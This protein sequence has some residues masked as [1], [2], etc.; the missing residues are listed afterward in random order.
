MSIRKLTKKQILKRSINTNEYIRAKELRVIGEDGAQLGVLTRE[1]ALQ[2]AR[3]LGVD[4]IEVA[5]KA[6]PPVARLIDF[7]KYLYLLSKKS[8]DENKGKTDIKE[9]KIGLFMAENDI[10]RIANRA[11]QFIKSGNQVKISLWLKGREL[12]KI[13][14]AR[15]IIDS[16]VTKIV[17][18]KI[19][20]GP[21]LQGKVFRLVISL[22]KSKNDKKRES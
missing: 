5:A 3:E 12:G 13:D 17:S 15:K 1:V 11:S 8:K 9:L 6:V 22:D 2:K 16:F 4:L 20:S 7:N 18:A 10:S 19:V 21:T 14:I